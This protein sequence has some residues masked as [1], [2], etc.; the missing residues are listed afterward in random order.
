MNDSLSFWR[1]FSIQLFAK[2]CKWLL[3]DAIILYFFFPSFIFIRY[4]GTEREWENWENIQ[5]SSIKHDSMWHFVNDLQHQ[6]EIAFS[7]RKIWF[8]LSFTS[9]MSIIPAAIRNIFDG[10][11]PNGSHTVWKLDQILYVRGAT[12]GFGFSTDLIKFELNFLFFCCHCC[13][14]ISCFKRLIIDHNPAFSY[15]GRQKQQ[16]WEERKK[17]NRYNNVNG[18]AKWPTND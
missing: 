7:R 9:N 16:Q 13:C 6:H 10:I 12:A 14:Q 17:R 15:N 11:Y 4:F 2:C 18:N 1:C 8:F 3:N 5:W